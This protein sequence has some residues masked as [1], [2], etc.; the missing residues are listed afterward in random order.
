L[1]ELPRKKPIVFDTEILGKFIVN[2]DKVTYVND[3]IINANN[4]KNVSAEVNIASESATHLLNLL[5]LSAELDIK[6]E[7]I[8]YN[9]KSF[10]GSLNEM[11]KK[12]NKNLRL[13][14][15]IGTLV[16]KNLESGEKELEFRINPTYFSRNHVLKDN[17]Y[18][19]YNSWNRTSVQ[20]SETLSVISN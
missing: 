20:N 1:Q 19:S 3:K 7:E 6:V 13:D 4:G 15:K 5:P 16:T 9:I 18:D 11:I 10:V 14:V 17:I 12:S 8:K 2:Q